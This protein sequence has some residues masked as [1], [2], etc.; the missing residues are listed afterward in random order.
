MQCISKDHRIKLTYYSPPVRIRALIKLPQNLFQPARGEC[1]RSEESNH[2]GFI[3]RKVITMLYELLVS[4]FIFV[5]F[6]LA[7][8]VLIQQGK[9]NMGLGNLGGG[10]QMLFGGSGGQ[11]LFQ[12][13]TWV[14][15][16]LFMAGSL[17]LAIMKSTS[18]RSSAYARQAKMP[19]SSAPIN[20]TPDEY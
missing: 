5:C 11:D 14:L 9:G 16:T 1:E 4:A 7:L 17:L 2:T 6:L 19:V 20:T 12:K 8:M 10:A 18:L 3:I 13:I 15:G